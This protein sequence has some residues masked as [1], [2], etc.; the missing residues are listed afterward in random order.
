MKIKTFPLHFTEE[1]LDKIREEAKK[2]GMSV[3]DFILYAI[4]LGMR[5]H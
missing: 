3:K 1:K 4:E 2:R 5:E